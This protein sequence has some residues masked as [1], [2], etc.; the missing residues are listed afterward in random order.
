MNIEDAHEKYELDRSKI[1][2]FIKHK[3][4]TTGTPQPSTRYE[5]SICEES[6]F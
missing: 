6:Y 1:D 4:Y 3:V 5:F 2:L